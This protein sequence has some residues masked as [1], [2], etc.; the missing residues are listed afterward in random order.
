MS[1]ATPLA[2]LLC[3][4]F[5]SNYKEYQLVKLPQVYLSKSINDIIT[6]SKIAA[7]LT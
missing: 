2:T 1:L 7:K 4:P 3:Q 5:L 6:I